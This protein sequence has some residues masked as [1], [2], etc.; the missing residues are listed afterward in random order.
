MSTTGLAGLLG[1]LP[2][3]AT[4]QRNLG[5]TGVVEGAQFS[6]AGDG[7]PA[8]PLSQPSPVLSFPDMAGNAKGNA[9]AAWGDG[10]ADGTSATIKAAQFCH[11]PAHANNPA[12]GNGKP[13][14]HG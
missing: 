10:T 12:C 1:L 14:S 9:V 13:P 11:R 5:G 6:A 4:W 8:T 2:T 3:L 7:G